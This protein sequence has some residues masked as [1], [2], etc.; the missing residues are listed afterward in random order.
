MVLDTSCI[1]R[2]YRCK[3]FWEKRK[4]YYL[5]DNTSFDNLDSKNYLKMNL[6][7]A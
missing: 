6:H 1:I 5:R 7:I 4:F 3:I 2:K